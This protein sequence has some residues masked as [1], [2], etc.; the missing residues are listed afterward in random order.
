[1]I[2]VLDPTTDSA[3]IDELTA[4]LTYVDGWATALPELRAIEALGDTPP[5]DIERATRYIVFPWRNTI[6]RLPDA[7]TFWRLRTARNRHLLTDAEQRQW[8]SALIGIAGLS[9]GSSVLSACALT[10]ARRFRIA[11]PDALGPTN[12]NRLVGSV[13]DLGVPK[14]TIAQRRVLEA[15][16]YSEFTVFENGY[17]EEVADAFLGVG[18]EPLAVLIE[19]M[20]DIPMK[21][22]IRR[23]ARAAGIPV[24]M[25]TDNGDNVILDI[26]RFDLEPDRALFHGR[27]SGDLVGNRVQL[28]NAIVGSEVTPRTRYSLTEVGR[29]IPSWPQLGTAATAAGAAA[30]Y[31]VRSIVCGEDVPSGR[32]RIDLDTAVLGDRAR[33]AQRPNELDEATFLAWLESLR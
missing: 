26:E 27:L 18:A 11:D 16:P 4:R 15:D 31:A 9:V 10:G 20:D 1:M 28:A 21:V 32:F 5:T 30:A 8:S 24:V 7:E 29:S 6:V 12:L 23:R 3:R 17:T 25:A 13:C 19:E 2:E 14:T 22:A 33:Q